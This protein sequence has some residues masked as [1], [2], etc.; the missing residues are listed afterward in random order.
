MPGSGAMSPS[1]LKTPSVTTRVRRYGSPVSG[2]PT[3]LASRS[4]SRS[5]STSLC[6]KTFRGAFDI[7]MPS[8]IDAWFRL[9]ETMRSASP[10]MTGITPVLAVKPDWKV[11]T[12]S[13]RLKRASSASSSSW[14]VIVPAMVRTAPEPA[15]NRST[16]RSAAS[17]SLG[18]WV[19][20]R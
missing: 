16:A 18:W 11:S 6:G 8:M 15:P 19:R 13:V 4:T 2:R 14:S 7:R 17:R 20:P 5:A 10:A 12:A 9:S 1:M 3:S